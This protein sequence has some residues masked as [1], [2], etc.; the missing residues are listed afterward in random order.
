MIRARSSDRTPHQRR[1]PGR[2]PAP[3]SRRTARTTSGGPS[4]RTSSATDHPTAARRLPSAVPI[5]RSG[6]SCPAAIRC[7]ATAFSSSSSTSSCT[8]PMCS[9]SPNPPRRIHDL[10]PAAPPTQSSPSAHGRHENHPTV[11]Q[12]RGLVHKSRPTPGNRTVY[13]RRPGRGPPLAAPSHDDGRACHHNSRMAR[14][15]RGSHHSERPPVPPYPRMNGR[16]PTATG[17]RCESCWVYVR[18]SPSPAPRRPTGCVPC[19]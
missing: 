12:G 11:G 6:C 13:Q 3:S 9:I 5:P 19:C 1:R 10:P 18:T 4:P 7:H 16:A 8:G 14:E 2:T 17:K 15:P